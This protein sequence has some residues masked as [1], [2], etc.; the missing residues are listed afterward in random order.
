MWYL[1][2]NGQLIA[3]F[4][5]GDGH[6]IPPSRRSRPLHQQARS[7]AGFNGPV[8]GLG[9]P[10]EG[11]DRC[12]TVRRHDDG[13]MGKTP[14]CKNTTSDGRLYV[15][16]AEIESRCSADAHCGG[17][18]QDT[19]DGTAYF[20]PLVVVQ[21]ILKDPKWTTWTKGPMPPA[22]PPSPPAPPP[23]PPVPKDWFNQ[24]DPPFCLATA[25]SSSPPME[26]P[27]PPPISG[28]SLNCH[29]DKPTLLAFAGPLSGGDIAVGLANK[30]TGS[31]KITASF[32]DI[33][34]KSGVTYKVRDTIAHK[35]LPDATDGTVS[36]MVGEHDISVLRLTPK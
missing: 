9:G 34:A 15:S 33:G 4:V 14:M 2:A 35:D 8:P 10:V 36:A 6:Q 22:L 1:S 29:T 28:G 32:K 18:S 30:C 21:S 11:N 3:S 19:K 24:V 31:Q 23:A 20:R 27:K 13:D 25:P 12:G 16:L 17:F 5:R 26:P 7:F